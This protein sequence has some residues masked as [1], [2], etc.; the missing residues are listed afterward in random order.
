M[1]FVF[2]RVEISARL[3]DDDGVITG[4]RPVGMAS[5][6]MRLSWMSHQTHHDAPTS[7]SRFLKCGVGSCLLL[8]SVKCVPNENTYR[9]NKVMKM[10]LLISAFFFVSVPALAQRV[11]FNDPYPDTRALE[12]WQLTLE[13]SGRRAGKTCDPL[14]TTGATRRPTRPPSGR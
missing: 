7:E 9:E 3:A 8:R 4:L 11:V 14:R 13:D 1:A 5:P 6:R 2:T 10:S 12:I